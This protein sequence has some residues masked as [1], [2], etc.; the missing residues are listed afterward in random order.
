MRQTALLHVALALSAAL[1]PLSA[2]TAQDQIWTPRRVEAVRGVTSIAMSP[3]GAR[4]AYTLAV[5]RI[6]GKDDDGAAWSELHVL[7]TSDG[8]DR[9]FVGGKVNVSAVAWTPN[10]SEIAFLAK[11]DGDK[12]TSLYAIPLLGGEARKKVEF[13]TS[14]KA[15]SFAPDGKR[16]VLIAVPPESA[17]Q[18]KLTEKGFKQSVYEEDERAAKLW[19]ADTSDAGAKPKLLSVEGH[20]YSVRWSPMDDRL[21]V[22]L[23]PTTLVDD[24]YMRQ[25]VKILD[26]NDG[27]LLA[28]I[29]NPGKM[30]AFEWS[31]NGA[32]IALACAT[33]IH[34]TS[35]GRMTIAPASGGTPVDVLGAGYLGDIGGF[36]WQGSGSLLCLLD[37]GVETS[38]EKIEVG[39]G[40]G[41][42][43]K[44]LIPTGVASFTAVS[45]S[46]DGQKAAFIG[47]RADHAPEVFTMAH[48]DTAP[49]RRTDSNPWM[50]NMRFAKQEAVTY[51]AR[52]GVEIQGV[53]I[54]PLSEQA[55]MR[56]PLILSVHG[57]P[58]AHESN[59][60]LTQY[61]RPGQMAAAKGMAVFYP[62][63]R[64]STGRGVAFA[65]LSQ[66]D[67]AG[68]EFDDLIDAVDHFI[69]VGLVDGTKVG[70][71]G[72]SYGG[73]ATAWC[74][75]RHSERFAAGV[76]FVGISN[77]ISKFGTTDIPN[78]E[79]YVH[80]LKRPWDDLE[81]FRER[82]PI[83]YAEKSKT[84]LLIMGGKDDTR[85]DPGQSKEMYRW[86]KLRGS[87]PVRL[88]QYPGEGH[89]NRKACARLDYSVRMLQWM[90]HYLTGPGGAAPP[91]EV[92]Y[93]EAVA[94]N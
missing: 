51:K 21:A 4:V 65:R 30:G 61:S 87:A 85:V 32:W 5:P 22:G 54:R 56:Y 31:P 64:G 33:D 72:G 7:S 2:A 3:D 26:A 1:A 20:V 49:V 92:E 78:E 12:Q 83:T 8:S 66:A 93:G 88:V 55:G 39:T 29:E 62:N 11:R 86:L 40:R 38:F 91:Y 15:F 46:A 36:G 58:E 45:L 80:A 75:T 48:G 67:A 81:F 73:Y 13:D 71:T 18:K 76:M 50:K 74:S 53:L 24:E 25:R 79:F 42:A 63:Y 77:K 47:S 60:W 89:G 94:T 35:A 69:A 82:S 59:G 23:A 9:T 28:G 52:D 16:V 84:P 44:V 41:G 68:K 43:K 34:E 14:I 17:E 90:E 27:R 6:A 70:V 19:I 57:G 37:Q 10:G